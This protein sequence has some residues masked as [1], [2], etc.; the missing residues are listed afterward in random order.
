VGRIP[1]VTLGVPEETSRKTGFWYG[2]LPDA[3]TPAAASFRIH[4]SGIDDVNV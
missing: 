3:F 1:T 4:W 2:V